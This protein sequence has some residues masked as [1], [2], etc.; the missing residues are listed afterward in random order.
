MRSGRV[1]SAARH[2]TGGAGQFWFLCV[3]PL[4]II[5]A[6]PAHAGDVVLSMP[7]TGNY[8]LKLTSFADLKF[9]TVI[10]QRY[11]YSCGSAALATLLH[12]HYRLPVDEAAV[13][14]AMFD[15]GDK[16]N[17]EKVGFSLLDMKKYLA[18]IGYQADGYRLGLDELGKVGIPAIAL[19]QIGTYKHFVV[20]KGVAGDHVLVGDSALGLRVLSADDFRQAWN[21]IA[22]LVH[23]TPMGVTSPLFNDADEWKMWTDANPLSAAVLVPA[24]APFLASLRVIYQIEPNQILP[25]PLLPKPL[26]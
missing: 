12:Y 24:L 18:S 23:D 7:S 6:Q 20:I 9:S 13:F 1:K 2:A 16:A 3:L 8:G 10:R 19:I 17:I 26:F 5:F 22:F 21:G 11:D 4:F 15:V 14:K 25:N